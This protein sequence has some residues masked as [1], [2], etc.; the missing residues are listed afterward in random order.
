[1]DKVHWLLLRLSKIFFFA[2]IKGTLL[3]ISRESMGQNT[4]II[5]AVLLGLAMP[6]E[7]Q[8]QLVA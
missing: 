6:L 8:S 1:M 7:E 4:H 5:Q 3:S 2:G